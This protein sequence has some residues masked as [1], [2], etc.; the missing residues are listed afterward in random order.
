[1]DDKEL[2]RLA[3]DGSVDA[4][5]TLVAKYQPKVFSMAMSFTRNRETADD[6]AQEVFLKAYL[7]LPKFHMKSEFGTWLYRI[8]SNL[9]I[10][11]ANQMRRHTGRHVRDLTPADLVPAGDHESVGEHDVRGH[12]ERA[13]HELPTLQRAVV[14]LRHFEG[15]STRQVSGILRC[16]EGT[17]KTHLF[18]GLEKMRDKLQHLRE[19]DQ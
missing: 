4:F 9:S 3:Q 11:Q 13:L 18:R 17:V 1:M 12:I 7:A 14:L 10:N 5:E 6:A 2:V 19:E 16:S 8:V 15:L